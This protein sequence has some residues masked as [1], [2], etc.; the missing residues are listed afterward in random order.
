MCGA[1][2]VCLGFS[3]VA[4]QRSGSTVQRV[5]ARGFQARSFRVRNISDVKRPV[6][7]PAAPKRSG[8]TCCPAQRLPAP[9]RTDGTQLAGAG[10]SGLACDQGE[11]STAAVASRQAGFT[12]WQAIETHRQHWALAAQRRLLAKPDTGRGSWIDHMAITPAAAG[13]RF[14]LY[15]RPPAPHGSDLLGPSRKPLHRNG[16][17]PPSP[18]PPPAARA[19]GRRRL[20]ERAAGQRLVR[21]LGVHRPDRASGDVVAC[22]LKTDPHGARPRGQCLRTHRLLQNSG[23]DA[24]TAGSGRTQAPAVGAA[25]SRSLPPGPRR[26]SRQAAR[27][28]RQVAHLPHG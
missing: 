7:A 22:T 16:S 10:S 9:A 5:Q 23:P 4:V 26:S 6:Q 11:R 27:R 17:C 8:P 3:A 24:G 2:K 12:A 13:L 25:P 28:C 1:L 15:S 18:P 21:L 20:L 19:A 14:S